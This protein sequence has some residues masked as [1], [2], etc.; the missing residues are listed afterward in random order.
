M[1]YS[2]CLSLDQ[3][4]ISEPIKQGQ[5]RVDSYK[6]IAMLKEIIKLEEREE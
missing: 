4:D 5:G 1:K 3:V 2:D 6:K